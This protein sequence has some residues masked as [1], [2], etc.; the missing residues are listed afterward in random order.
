[1]VGYALSFAAGIWTIQQLPELPGLPTLVFGCVFTALLFKLKFRNAA[2]FC[3]GLLWAVL[4]GSIGLSDRLPVD[5]ESKVI[6]IQGCVTGLPQQ[7]DRRVRF[8][9]SNILGPA[10]LPSKLRLSWY[11]TKHSIKAGQCWLF[12]VKLKRPHGNLNPGGFDYERWLLSEGIGATGYI[13][14]K[15]EPILLSESANGFRMSIWRQKLS[16]GLDRTGVSTKHLGIIKALSIGE[17]E[18][19]NSDQ[20]DI[21]RKTGTV[22][23]IAISGLHI[24]L[25]AGLV[26]FVVVKTWARTGVLRWSPHHVAALSALTV[27]ALYAGL[28]GFSV[29]TQRALIMLIVVMLSVIWQKNARPANTLALALF[30]VLSMDPLALLSPGFWLSFLAVCVIA[31]VSAGRLRE[32]NRWLSALNIHWTLALALAPVLLFFFQQTSFIAPLA[33]MFAVPLVSLLIAPILLPAVLLLLL[34][35]SMANVLLLFVDKLLQGLLWILSELA[36][37]PFAVLSFSQ[38]S[39]IAVIFFLMG[40]FILLAPKGFPG[41]WLGCIMFCPMLFPGYVRLESGEAKL[42]LLDVGQGLSAVLQTAN[43]NL[44][45]DTGIRFDS[46]S[47]SGRLVLLPFLRNQGIDKVDTLIISHGDN[48]HIGGAA[49]LLAGIGTEAV[50]S[51]VPE[52]IDHVSVRY[53]EAGQEW[54]WD[55]V[56]FSML[57]PGKND[58]RR[59]NNDSSCVLKVQTQYG[60]IL[61]TGDIEKSTEYWLVENNGSNL[62]S[63][64]LIVPHH[65]S[66]TSSSHPFLKAVAP[67][68][69]LIPAGYK[70]RFGFPHRA[71]LKRLDEFDIHWLDAGQLG[72]ISVSLTSN[73]TSI[74][75][76]RLSHRRYW[77]TAP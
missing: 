5:L 27:G 10:G 4:Y 76:R 9:L 51:S 11:Q 33:N 18:M 21:F 46:E 14:E 23:L 38:P 57:A 41:R 34:M 45:F 32:T 63:D 77:H 69:A 60:S 15:P 40:I 66:N 7:S 70:N 61:L 12:S 71:V 25:I 44:V 67:N 29:P 43:H 26:Y 42:T 24:G 3:V 1:M 68:H 47:D 35:P 6:P 49:S 30:A 59:S 28:A 74:R 72:A 65:G 17:R 22:H 62:Q 13:R 75:A 55:G 58:N 19:L 37:L 48:D 2:F 8:N 39:M 36:D 20:W 52:K 50:Y 16:D 53:C 54:R 73:G 64:I 56:M 31:Y